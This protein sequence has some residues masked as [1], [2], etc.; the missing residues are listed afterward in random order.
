MDG[1]SEN[2]RGRRV[3]TPK[4]LLA[5]LVWGVLTTK[6]P[7][8]DPP[9]PPPCRITPDHQSAGYASIDKGLRRIVTPVVTLGCLQ[10]VFGHGAQGLLIMDYQLAAGL[11]R[12]P[13]PH[14]PSVHPCMWIHQYVVVQ[15]HSG[16]HHPPDLRGRTTTTRPLNRP[17][18]TPRKT[19][20]LIAPGHIVRQ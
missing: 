14:H 9:Y 19:A 12:P 17:D 8:A 15:W 1:Q 13:T 5:R 4:I 7:R 10:G 20:F 6:E 3:T 16:P 11:E 2:Q 18:L